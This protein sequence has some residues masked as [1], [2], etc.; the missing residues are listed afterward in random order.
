V[1][2]LLLTPIDQG[3]KTLEGQNTMCSD[4]FSIFI[5]IAIGFTHIFADS[6]MLLDISGSIAY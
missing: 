3:L 2:N 4:V 6:G 1:E 5:G